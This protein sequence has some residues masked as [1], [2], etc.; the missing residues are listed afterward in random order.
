MVRIAN[1]LPMER[2]YSYT[3]HRRY[4]IYRSWKLGCVGCVRS[5]MLYD[6]AIELFLIKRSLDIKLHAASFK[7]LFRDKINY[8]RVTVSSLNI[9][10]DIMRLLYLLS[11]IWISIATNPFCLGSFLTH[12][13]ID[14]MTSVHQWL[15]AGSVRWHYDVGHCAVLWT[16]WTIRRPSWNRKSCYADRTQHAATS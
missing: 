13:H 12:P 16:D 3:T 1:S 9:W 11:P 10:R 8:S 4:A 7:F 14:P 6:V 15:S 5:Y 2:G